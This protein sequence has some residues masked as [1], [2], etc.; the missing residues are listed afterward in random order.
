[1]IDILRG[2]Q[3]Q[4][5]IDNGH[6]QLSVYG[7]GKQHTVEAWRNVVRALLHQGLVQES[8]DGYPVLSLNALSWEVLRGER[9][10]HIA[11]AAATPRRGRSDAT[12][13]AGD[14][15]P[16]DSAL[17]DRL[18]SLRKKLA[19]QSGVPPY[20]IFHDATLREMVRRAPV[21]LEDFATI[22]G[23]GQAKLVRY[24]QIFTDEIRAARSQGISD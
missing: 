24:G 6:A 12:H 8:Q 3:S 10:V 21:S 2:S 19:D 17:F 11:A 7:I 1:L 16:A 18:R 20:V 9:K 4:R 22:P 15:T 5:L 13:A 14:D 23:V